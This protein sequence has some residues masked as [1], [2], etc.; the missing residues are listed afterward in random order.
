MKKIAVFPGSFDPITLGHTSIINRA[1]PLFDEIIIAIGVNSE[2]KYMFDLALRKKWIETT[3]ENEP[4]VR[5]K[6]YSGL[7]VN[8]CIENNAYFIL[9]GLRNQQDFEFERSIAQM[10]QQLQSKIETIFLLTELEYAAINSSIVRDI[11]RNGGDI[12]QF[13]PKAVSL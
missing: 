1:L 13:V 9:R 12:S 6:N 4:K 10:N 3:Y 8:F 7:T 2:K 5:V 11:H